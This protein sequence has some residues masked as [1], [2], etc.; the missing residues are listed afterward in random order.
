MSADTGD[1]QM[2]APVGYLGTGKGTI[3]VLLG[4]SPSYYRLHADRDD[5]DAQ[6]A[7][8]VRPGRTAR[9]C[10][11]R[12]AG[13][14]SSR[15]SR[16][17]ERGTVGSAVTPRGTDWGLA[18]LVAIAVATGLGTWFAGSPGAAWVFGVHTA[19][20]TVIAFVLVYKLRR[21]LPR[22][23]ARRDRRSAA[24]VARARARHGRA[25]ERL[26]VVERRLDEPR[27]LHAAGLARGARRRA[28]A[29][30]AG[31]R[32]AARQA[33][34]PARRGR[35][36]P[37][38]DRARARRRRGRGLAGPAPGA[39]RAR[40]A[41]PAAALH[42]LLRV[43]LVQRQ[44]VPGD[45]VGG[46]PAAAGPRGGLVAG[47][48]RAGG[49]ATRARRR[50]ARPRRRAGRHAR[51]HRRLLLDPALARRAAGAAARRRG[52]RAAGAGTCA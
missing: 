3:E 37:V 7:V 41:G 44:R 28:R 46:R 49:A 19:G 21:V 36:A 25:G 52:R 50:R 20:G 2:E 33:A 9:R 43:G 45:V 23:V 51:L 31:P 32:A 29:R 11:R 1:V 42:R 18:L 26:R 15:S 17:P 30:R 47:R 38:P 13:R 27:R 35:P 6:L 24:G 5:F 12:S 39:A 34:A 8:L 16:P 40:A 14:R 4:H 22:L 48:R 10:A